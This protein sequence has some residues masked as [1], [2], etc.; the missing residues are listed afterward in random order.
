MLLSN[1]SKSKIHTEQQIWT[2]CAWSQ[3]VERIVGIKHK[4]ALGTH[5]VPHHI[6]ILLNGAPVGYC[7]LVGYYHLWYEGI[8]SI[9]DHQ[10]VMEH[11]GC[12]YIGFEEGLLLVVI[13]GT[14]HT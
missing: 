12:E 6:R 1:C 5:I 8:G 11:T 3:I 4:E 10:S 7:E 9:V 13:S 14:C 2:A